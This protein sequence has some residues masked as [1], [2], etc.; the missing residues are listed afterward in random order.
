MGG[1]INYAV[2]RFISL[3]KKSTANKTLSCTVF[4]HEI[5]LHVF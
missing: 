5:H 2:K 3:D 1:H 4:S